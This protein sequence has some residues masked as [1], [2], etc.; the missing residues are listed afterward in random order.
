MTR[1]KISDDK[2]M[3]CISPGPVNLVHIEFG[4]LKINH[5][6]RVPDEFLSQKVT[7]ETLSR[8]GQQS[9]CLDHIRSRD[10][11][12]ILALSSYVPLGRSDHGVLAKSTIIFLYPTV[13]QLGRKMYRKLIIQN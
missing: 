9:S 10:D 11:N 3:S 5:R 4:C 1:K 2:I 12:F 7:M 6:S 13:D 8:N